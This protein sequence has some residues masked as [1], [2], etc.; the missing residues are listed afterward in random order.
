MRNR[1]PRREA[2]RMVLAARGFT[3]T[4]LSI[5]HRGAGYLYVGLPP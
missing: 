3:G 2:D 5:E 1:T 4:S